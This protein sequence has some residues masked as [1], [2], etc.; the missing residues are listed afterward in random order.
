MSGILST[1]EEQEALKRTAS[2][3]VILKKR[4]KKK[5]SKKKKSKK[6]A[7]KNHK[8]SSSSSSEHSEEEEEDVDEISWVE[9]T[10]VG[11]HVVGPEARL[12]HLSQADKPLERRCSHGRV[13]Q[14]RKT[15]SRKR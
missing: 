9:K 15:Y 10:G 14:S 5:K 4:W 2:Q 3:K 11:E 13:C 7:K 1:E 8:E 6:M 12:A